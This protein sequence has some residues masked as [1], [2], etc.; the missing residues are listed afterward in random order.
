[1]SDRAPRQGTNSP[2][3]GSHAPHLDYFSYFVLLFVIGDGNNGSISQPGFS[4]R[5]RTAITTCGG[6]GV[7]VRSVVWASRLPGPA[8]LLRLTTINPPPQF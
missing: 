4:E 6:S 3:L 5:I 2:A 8:G 7:T 1:M